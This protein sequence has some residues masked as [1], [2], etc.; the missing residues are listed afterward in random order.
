MADHELTT[1]AVHVG[2]AEL[3]DVVVTCA[4]DAVASASGQPA[5]ALGDAA[6]GLLDNAGVDV[7]LRLLTDTADAA[8][9]AGDGPR[10]DALLDR[11]VTPRRSARRR[12]R[13]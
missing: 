1:L 2:T 8:A 13:S 5:A 12:P 9:V 11:A 3:A 6:I 7:P 4:A 10:A